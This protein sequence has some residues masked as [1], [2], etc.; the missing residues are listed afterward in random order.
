MNDQT[1]LAEIRKDLLKHEAVGVDTSTWEAT[2]FFRIIDRQSAEL[3]KVKKE[4]KC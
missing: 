3:R 2:L 1:R 4:I